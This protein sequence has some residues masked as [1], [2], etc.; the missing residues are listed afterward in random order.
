MKVVFDENGFGLKWFLMKVDFNDE[1]D[2]FHLNFDESVHGAEARV[3][4]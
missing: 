2:H 1:I 4:G 3:R